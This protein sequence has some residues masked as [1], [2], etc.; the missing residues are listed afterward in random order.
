MTRRQEIPWTR[1]AVEATA[2]VASILLAFSIDAWWG[3]HQEREHERQVLESLL[4]EFNQ[5]RV[6]LD[7]AL[8]SFTV[9]RKSVTRVLM[10]AGQNLS[11]DDKDVIGQNV[12]A[13]FDY[14]TFDP[15]T[16]A[17]DSLLNAGQ[18][19]LIQNLELRTRLA[20]WSGL[21]SDYKEEERELDYVAYREFGPY[22]KKIAPLP[23]VDEISPGLFQ[24]QWQ[25]AIN[26][27]EFLNHLGRLSY[28]LESNIIEASDIGRE[29]DLIITLIATELEQ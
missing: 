14:W 6:E 7:R 4:A 9:S 10:F 25:G 19:D 11:D 29:I 18:L 17:I 2:I 15:S 8:N 13:L 22:Y 23:N 1:I 28:I 20:G 16:G 5:N 24:S 12:F 27:V 3:E 26:D 21:V